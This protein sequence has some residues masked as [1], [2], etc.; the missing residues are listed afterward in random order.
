[1]N[2]ETLEK[3]VIQETRL[4]TR[5]VPSIARSRSLILDNSFKNGPTMLL[6]TPHNP[7]LNFNPIYSMVINI[8]L[9]VFS[10]LIIKQML[11]FSFNY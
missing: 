1:V 10:R 5:W 8:V 9:I 11:C 6:F 4:T 7:Y 2:H 3:W